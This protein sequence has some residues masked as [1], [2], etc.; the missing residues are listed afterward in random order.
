[1]IAVSLAVAAIA[2]AFV[3][4][5][6]A[7]R[8]AQQTAADARVDAANKAGRLAIAAADVATQKNRADDEKE[9]ADA[10]DQELETVAADGDAAGA[11]ERVLRRKARAASA[12]STARD[13]SGEVRG[14][15]PDPAVA[16]RPDDDLAKPGD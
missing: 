13:D 4:F 7:L 14:G 9:R 2:G 6:V 16:R 15:R 10:L 12:D 11:R 3:W 8:N 1:M 5:G